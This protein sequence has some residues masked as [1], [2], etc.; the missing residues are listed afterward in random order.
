MNGLALPALGRLLLKTWGYG[1]GT[2][3]FAM[4][5]SPATKTSTMAP[6]PLARLEKEISEHVE[7]IHAASLAYLERLAEYGENKPQ[8]VEITIGAGPEGVSHDHHTRMYCW[9][10]RYICGHGSNGYIYC[11]R[12][13][14]QLEE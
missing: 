11:T 2:G 4:N 12:R 14:C 7:A 8:G 6:E 3:E 9:D 10:A 1:F 13:V 5:E